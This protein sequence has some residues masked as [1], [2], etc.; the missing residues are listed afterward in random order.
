MIMKKF[1]AQIFIAVLLLTG[2]YSQAQVYN[3][4][5]TNPSGYTFDDPRFWQGQLRPPNPCT[6]CGINVFA[7][8]TIPSTISNKPSTAQP[9]ATNVF[10]T[11][12][13]PPLAASD[14][15]TRTLTV[16]MRFTASV[17]G[18]ITGVRFWQNALM[19]W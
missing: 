19:S 18:Q 14:G 5:T 1:Y 4:I 12:T 15:P 17:P 7:P 10:T 6:G 11:Q 16:G 8:T 3:S 13:P 2:F 9:T